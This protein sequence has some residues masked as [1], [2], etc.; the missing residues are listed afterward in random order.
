M[1]PAYLLEP[2]TFLGQPV[3]GGVNPIMAEVLTAVE[4][5]LHATW[6]ASG[7]SDDFFPWAGLTE[8][9]IG[10]RPAAGLHSS[11]SAVDLNVTQCPYIVTRTGSVLGGEAAAQGQQAMRQR[12]VDVYDRAVAFGDWTRPTAD[13]S[14][15]VNDTI[16]VTYDRFRE[17]SDALVYYLCWAFST[18]PV[19]VDR[20]PIPDVHHLPDGDNAFGAIRDGELARPAAD[21][22]DMIAKVLAD[23]EWQ[24]THP[25]WPRTPEQEYWQMLRDYEMVRIPM[26]YGNPNE[27]VRATR[28]PAHGFLQLRR[29][30]V[31][32]MIHIG[33]QVLGA[34]RQMRWGASDFGAQQSG[35]VMHFDLGSHAG[36][37]PG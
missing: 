13:V 20:P 12:A 30:L 28:N 31:C 34:S 17:V 10:W 29:E 19:R 9:S 4:A 8:P 21:A 14:I 15:R 35:D 32:S 6:K 23:P 37:T 16:E 1:P 27:P 5:D 18:V 22:I 33:D 24:A 3:R 7:E 25:H 2:F 26:L 36:F 11:G